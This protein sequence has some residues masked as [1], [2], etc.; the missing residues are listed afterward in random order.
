[1]SDAQEIL[2]DLLTALHSFDVADEDDHDAD[3][4]AIGAVFAAAEA[5]TKL[6]YV[7]GADGRYR[8]RG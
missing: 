6:G 1:M 2:L 3:A 4:E 8:R 5:L 7:K